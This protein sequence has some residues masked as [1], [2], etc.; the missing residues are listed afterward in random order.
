MNTGASTAVPFSSVLDPTEGCKPEL[1]CVF[2]PQLSHSLSLEDVP[3][4]CLLDLSILHRVEDECY[5]SQ[6]TSDP[7]CLLT[8]SDSFMSLKTAS[9]L[10]QK[11]KGSLVWG[12]TWSQVSISS[13]GAR[14][15]IPSLS[16]Q[17]ADPENCPTNTFCVQS[18]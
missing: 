5:L 18:P 3:K 17:S 7:Q 15:K 6:S 9:S 8:L 2:P 14:D 1:G 16:G 4:V 10:L 11:G 12:Q 13:E